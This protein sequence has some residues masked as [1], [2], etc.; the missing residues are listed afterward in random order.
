MEEEWGGLL[1]GN[2]VKEGVHRGWEWQVWVQGRGRGWQD[3]RRMKRK[4]TGEGLGMR[5]GQVMG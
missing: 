2:G 4:W 1:E 5:G 3:E